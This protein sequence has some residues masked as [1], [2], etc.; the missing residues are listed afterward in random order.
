MEQIYGE[1]AALYDRLMSDVDYEA[2]AGYLDRLLSEH[3]PG[4]T[5]AQSQPTLIDCACGTG[6][7]TI[8]LAKRGYSL[9]GMDRSPDMLRIA[10]QK[11]LAAGL[12]IPFVQRDMQQ[13]AAHRPV[14][15]VTACCDGV[16]YLTKP[17]E[18][19]AFFDAVANALKPEGL[20][21]FDVSSAY[22]LEHVL[23]GH[24][25]GEAE[26][27]LAYLWCNNFDCDTRLVQMDLT[28]FVRETGKDTYRRFEET[29]M[30][31]AHTREEIARWLSESGF[32]LCGVYDAFTW[33][34]PET[35]SE[36]IQWIARRI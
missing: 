3:L 2:W 14:D 1:F 9:I 18:V 6:T 12:R 24:T 33:K 17:Q 27:D 8:A 16:N 32:A 19:R 25:F 4:R 26:S 30:Q 35:D 11:A 20:L 15:A 21:L 36:R 13:I 28:F 34:E 22:K 10:Q 23:G 5:D 31:R 7:M 29:H